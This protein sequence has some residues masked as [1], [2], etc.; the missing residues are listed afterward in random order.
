MVRVIAY[1]YAG[2]CVLTVIQ[3]SALAVALFRD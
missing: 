3:R 1:A 2:L